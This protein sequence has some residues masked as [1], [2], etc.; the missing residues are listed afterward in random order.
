MFGITWA[1]PQIAQPVAQPGRLE[2]AIR[3]WQRQLIEK[4]K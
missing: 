1:A 4:Q 2:L 3:D